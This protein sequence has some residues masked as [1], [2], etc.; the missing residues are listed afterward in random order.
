MRLHVSGICTVNLFQ[1]VDG[2]LLGHVHVLAATVVALAGVAFGVFVGQLR[3]LG[4]HDGGRGIVF[5]GDE[6]DVVL[7]SR[8][9]GLNG[10][11]NFGVG[12]RDQNVAVVH[13]GSPKKRC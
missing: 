9:F 2:Q 11:P 8:V 6:L 12:L 13:G 3:A 7:L 5:A 1:A 10:S 4:L